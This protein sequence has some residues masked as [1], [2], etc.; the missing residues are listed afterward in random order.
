MKSRELYKKEQ[1]SQSILKSAF[2]ADML[3]VL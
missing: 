2:G 1:K 3:S